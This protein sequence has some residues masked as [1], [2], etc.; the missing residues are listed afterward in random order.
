MLGQATRRSRSALRN[1]R[2]C[3]W[4]PTDPIPTSLARL[5]LAQS[6][7]TRRAARLPERCHLQAPRREPAR[8]TAPRSQS[9]REGDPPLLASR[10]RRRWDAERSVFVRV[11]VKSPEKLAAVRASDCHLVIRDQPSYAVDHGLPHALESPGC[12]NSLG[13]QGEA[14]R[15]FLNYDLRDLVSNSPIRRRLIEVAL[16]S[17]DLPNDKQFVSARGHAQAPEEAGWACSLAPRLGRCRER[18]AAL[19]RLRVVSIERSWRS[20]ERL[21]LSLV[22]GPDRSTSR[23]TRC[24]AA[25][26]PRSRRT[27]SRSRSRSRAV[28]ARW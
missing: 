8:C 28:L 25:C 6:A 20:L 19:P 2:P 17:V 24:G 3:R 1:V 11:V 7:G 5:R 10:F 15:A 22:L 21:G 14:D 18:A 23:S 16:R 26:Q 4:P 27:P 13:S 9:P 12:C